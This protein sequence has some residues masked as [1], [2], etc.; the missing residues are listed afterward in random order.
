MM[1]SNQEVPSG[2]YVSNSSDEDCFYVDGKGNFY[3]KKQTGEKWVHTDKWNFDHI[4]NVETVN[5]TQG[6]DASLDNHDGRGME[7]KVSAH[8]GVTVS[9]LM[10]WSYVNPN[11]NQAKVWAGVD[12]GP[13]KGASM[14]AGVWYDKHG[15]LHLKLSTSNVIPHVDFGGVVVINPKTISDLEK[16]TAADKQF[17]KGFTEGATLGLA[18]KPPKVLTQGVAVVD[19]VGKKVLSWFK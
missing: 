11:G 17:A 10:R 18:S 8:I 12:G 6:F 13:G 2:Y 7:V 1:T 3:F 19:K 9:D 16:P 15:D 5:A 14:D 4:C